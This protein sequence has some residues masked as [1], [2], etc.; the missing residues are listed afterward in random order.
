MSEDTW[1]IQHQHLVIFQLTS[2]QLYHQYSVVL[3]PT[4]RPSALICYRSSSLGAAALSPL[5]F[6]EASH[7]RQKKLY[8][9]VV[10]AAAVL[11]VSDHVC[12]FHLLLM[13]RC[14]F[15]FSEFRSKCEKSS[16]SEPDIWR[17]SRK[18]SRPNIRRLISYVR[19]G[20]IWGGSL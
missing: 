16:L 8:L 11:H 1:Q 18:L 6:V 19:N 20:A 14:L 9:H 13:C 7:R 15:G 2:L 17:K 12:T 10:A 3:T 4:G 5:S